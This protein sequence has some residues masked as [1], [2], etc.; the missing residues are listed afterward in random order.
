MSDDYRPR[1]SFDISEEQAARKD[2][3]INT[4]GLLKAL[5]TVILD[6]LLDLIETHGQ[7]ICG[8]IIDHKVK[9]RE[10]MKALKDAERKAKL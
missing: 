4:H 3:L 6:D 9:P 10:I 7:I 2:R 1:L 5:F 8:V